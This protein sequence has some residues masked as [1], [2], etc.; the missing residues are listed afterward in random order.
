MKS[1][2]PVLALLIAETASAAVSIVSPSNGEIVPQ[3]KPIQ[4]QVARA[5][6]AELDQMLADAHLRRAMRKK[7][8]S[9][10]APVRLAWT[11]GEGPWHV[12]V[13]RKPDGKVF[14]DKTVGGEELLVDS[15]EIA[16]EWSWT[17]EGPSGKAEGSF[18][19]EDLAPR[20]IAEI[21]NGRDLGGRIGLNGRRVR[22][23]LVFRN[24]GLNY[25]ANIVYY[26]EDEVRQLDADGKLEKMGPQGEKLH[27]RIANGKSISEKRHRLIN[28][29][30]S[31]PGEERL[32][33][34]QKA[35][36]LSRFGIRSDIDLRSDS[37]CFGMTGSPLGSSVT[38][39]HLSYWGYEGL[40]TPTGTNQT[41]NVFRVFLDQNNYPIDFHCIAGMDRTGTVAFLL[42]AL[43]GVSEEDIYRDYF[44]TS[45]DD[46]MDGKRKKIDK[47]FEF[48]RT[49]PG[50]TL[51]EMA[52][53]YFRNLG[54]TQQEIDAF[55]EW[56]LE[57]PAEIPPRTL[58]LVP[59]PQEVKIA[60]GTLCVKS[61]DGVE[62]SI[63][64]AKGLPASGYEL[65]VSADGVKISAADE[66]GAFYGRQT[67][68]QLAQ[69]TS[70]GYS[71]P[72]CEIR[73][74]PRFAWRGVMFDDCRHFFGKEA[75]KRTLDA[76]AAHK[77]NVFHWHLTE[78]QAW[79]L[80]VP[81]FPELVTY[82]AVRS[83]SEY[84]DGLGKNRALDGTPY[85]PYY[86][87]EADIKEV[88]AYAKARHIRVVPE[89][90]LPGHAVAAIAA[91]P[92][93]CCRGQLVPREPWPK[94]GISDDIF[95]AG[96]DDAIRFLE[97]VLDYVVSIFPDE[98]VHI[99]GDEAPKAR[100]NACPKCQA[101]M[102][103]VGAKDAA[104]LQGWVTAHFTEY[105][106]KKGRRAIGWD[107][108]AEAKI[109]ADTMVMW[110]RGR[111]PEIA[112]E[113][114]RRGHDIVACPSSHC[115]FDFRQNSVEEHLARG[116]GYPTRRK[117]P[118]TLAMVHSFNPLAGI[119]DE[120]KGRIAGLQCN[121]WSEHILTPSEFEWKLWPR[122]AAIAEI[123]WSGPGAHPW[124]DFKRRC[125][126]AMSKLARKG[127]N[128]CGFDS[129]IRQ[130]EVG[131]LTA[132]ELAK[133]NEAAC[134]RLSRHPAK[135]DERRFVWAHRCTGMDTR[136]W[137]ETVRAAKACGM[138]D[139]IANLAWGPDCAYPSEVLSYSTKRA[140][141]A[142]QLAECLAACR[143][144]GLK[145]HVWNVCFRTWNTPR[146]RLNEFRVEER[147]QVDIKGEVSDKYLCPSHP[148]NRRQLVDAM[149]EL[150]GKGV[151]GV[152]FDYIRYEN[153]H[154]CFC[155]RC[156]DLFERHIGKSVADWP[157]D[158]RHRGLHRS[159]WEAFR[160]SIISEI[161]REASAQVHARYPGVEVSAA[162]FENPETS[163]IEQ[164]Q[165][166]PL[167]CREKWLDFVCPMT[168]VESAES[169]G[170]NIGKCRGALPSDFPV[171]PGIGL[172]VWKDEDL[173]FSRY[174]DQVSTLREMDFGG[175]AVFEL[176]KRFE[177]VM[178]TLK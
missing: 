16:R 98:V 90:E 146:E 128:V 69:K 87:T 81:K 149:V 174:A 159:Q 57:D 13:A 39:H 134:A 96:N 78:D 155:A 55:R 156:R 48:L 64:G 19:T 12:V 34:E 176:T 122:A 116:Y 177:S 85:G 77:M 166:W 38:W 108:V 24:A 170:A 54:F 138:T 93:L 110:W 9:A 94:W 102:K 97:Q 105:L 36:I 133:T 40:Y 23:G 63:S 115:Y 27:Q 171:Y 6:L 91:Y 164:G 29:E 15:L 68:A 114:A 17:V 147:L 117:A 152:H 131:S 74:W 18:F 3:L 46:D 45:F 145:L 37:E 70:A 76:M 83:Q 178:R 137:D 157:R 119:P 139:L 71:L 130:K 120:Q 42:E 158:V 50:N 53:A 43:L 44:F 1:T 75:V 79:R 8:G 80:V 58:D 4:A 100:W 125:D 82:G 33:P 123:G 14:C 66:A 163:P 92:N 51:A 160:Q 26:T 143:R 142:D 52:E 10:P 148:K 31:S 22:Q 104:A 141:G 175:Y 107:E 101:R 86:Y 95:C 106:A 162:V 62:V 153:S 49:H 56:M 61:L 25:N 129:V 65:R 126:E 169:F 2:L 113:A 5:S 32:S 151:D 140:K 11:G 165:D 121:V 88:L 167:W 127:Y 118:L 41:R 144:H 173:D 20:Q 172:N 112:V 150:A 89:I 136:N 103:A 84:P 47:C 73:D 72:C 124:V 35:S 109:P 28:A 21:P 135:P 59:Y 154:Y 168:Y 132:E 30:K 7:E 161:V 99:G 67:L 60:E 111:K